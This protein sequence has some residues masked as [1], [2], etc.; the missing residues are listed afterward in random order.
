MLFVRPDGGVTEGDPKDLL[1]I[2]NKELI[3]I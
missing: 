2:L 3:Y 1:K